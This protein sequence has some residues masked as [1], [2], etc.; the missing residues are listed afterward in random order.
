MRGQRA[1]GDGLRLILLPVERPQAAIPAIPILG[2]GNPPVRREVPTPRRRRGTCRTLGLATDVRLYPE[3]ARQEVP[4]E[5]QSRDGSLHRGD[6]RHG[7]LLSEG[8]TPPDRD[9]Q[10][11]GVHGKTPSQGL[12]QQG[13]WRGVGSTPC[14][15]PD[16][17]AR[18]VQVHSVAPYEESMAKAIRIAPPGERRVRPNRSPNMADHSPE[19]DA[20][21]QRGKCARRIPR[22]DGEALRRD[23]KPQDHSPPRLRTTSA[24]EVQG[25][26]TPRGTTGCD[27]AG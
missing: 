9:R 7:L 1:D 24:T 21:T 25:N 12:R 20:D 5:W 10:R 26:Q 4:K 13:H 17:G 6:A 19:G 15:S 23:G 22:A 11:K 27:G 3:T 16:T 18:P 14:P 8:R 2:A